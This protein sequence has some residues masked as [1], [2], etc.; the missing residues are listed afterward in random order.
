MVR[1]SL[2]ALPL[3]FLSFSAVSAYAQANDIVLPDGKAK[4]LIQNTCTECHGLDTVVSTPMSPEKWRETVKRM[5][6][7]GATLSPEEIDTVVDYMTVY[8]S[9]DKVN[10]N[11]AGPQ[12][13]QDSLEITPAQATAILQYRKANGHFKDLASL[14][15]VPGLDAKKLEAKKDS[16]TF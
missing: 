3:V 15:K 16:I 10:V 13:L 14:Q 9:Q 11:T 4:T 5:V 2:V 7:R 12:E 1:R 8:F 6:K